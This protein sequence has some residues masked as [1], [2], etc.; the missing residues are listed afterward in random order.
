MLC[1]S[2][3]NIKCKFEAIRLI[4]KDELH[5]KVTLIYGT[6]VKIVQVSPQKD[7]PQM[8]GGQVAQ[9]LAGRPR[10][11]RLAPPCSLPTP[12]FAW[13]LST[14]STVVCTG[15]YLNYQPSTDLGRL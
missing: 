2:I 1:R 3:D 5:I 15:R 9:S 11:G 14:A 10:M 13:K 8:V 4:S 6:N 7:A 12:G